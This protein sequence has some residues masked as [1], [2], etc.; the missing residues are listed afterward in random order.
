MS[1]AQ[2]V[3]AEIEQLDFRRQLTD[4]HLLGGERHH[5]LPTVRH[6]HEAGGDGSPAAP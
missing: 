2:R 3:L 6:R 5:D 4:R 1:V